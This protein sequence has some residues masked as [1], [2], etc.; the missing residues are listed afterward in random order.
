MTR[1]VSPLHTAIEIYKQLAYGLVPQAPLRLSGIPLLLQY[2]GWHQSLQ[3]CQVR[4][5]TAGDCE[6]I[7]DNHT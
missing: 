5:K 2:N 6:L 7:L 1:G 3:L 4:R